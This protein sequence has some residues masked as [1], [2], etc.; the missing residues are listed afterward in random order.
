MF[1]KNGD[2]EKIM[3]VVDPEDTPETDCKSYKNQ[4]QM[5]KDKICW[6][7]SCNCENEESKDK[8]ER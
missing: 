4:I 8:L 6:N 3:T 2:V 1:I 7:L 5:V